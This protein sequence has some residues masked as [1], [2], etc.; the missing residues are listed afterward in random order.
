MLHRTNIVL[1]LNAAFTD[2]RKVLLS[3]YLIFERSKV[4]VQSKYSR[5]IILHLLDASLA[6]ELLVRA[7]QC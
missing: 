4:E 2:S 5:A 7:L 1:I 3:C 6:N